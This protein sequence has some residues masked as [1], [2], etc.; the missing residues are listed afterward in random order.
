[1][2]TCQTRI[3][4]NCTQEAGFGIGAVHSLHGIVEL[5]GANS[6]AAPRASDGNNRVNGFRFLRTGHDNILTFEKRKK[7]I[8]LKSQTLKFVRLSFNPLQNVL[9]M[10]VPRLI[11]AKQNI[12]IGVA[13]GLEIDAGRRPLRQLAELANDR[14]AQ[15]CRE[16]K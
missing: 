13:V 11:G 7:V 5:G 3:L 10:L 2:E 16:R 6:S 1:M 4:E 15:S 9:R 12:L 14:L 8:R